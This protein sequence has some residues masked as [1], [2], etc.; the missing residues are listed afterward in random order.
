[1]SDINL[2]TSLSRNSNLEISVRWQIA[3]PIQYQHYTCKFHGPVSPAH[4][5]A[6]PKSHLHLPPL[7]QSVKKTIIQFSELN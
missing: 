4:S 3:I 1:V 6:H 5:V 2:D 7:C